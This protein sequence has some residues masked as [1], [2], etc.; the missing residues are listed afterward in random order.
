MAL[1]LRLSSEGAT[2][3]KKTRKRPEVNKIKIYGI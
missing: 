2:E 3:K 1:G